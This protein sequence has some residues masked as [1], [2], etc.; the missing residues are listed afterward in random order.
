MTIVDALFTD[1][2]GIDLILVIVAF[3]AV[4]LTALWRFGKLGIPTT[5]LVANLASGTSL[6]LAVRSAVTGAPMSTVALFLSLS[7][8]AHVTDLAC[9]W[10]SRR[11][12]PWH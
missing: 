6:I 10:R 2:R 8:V 3:E 1:G 9:R 12:R 4:A 5:E 7:F 11:T